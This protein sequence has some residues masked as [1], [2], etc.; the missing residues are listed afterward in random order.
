MLQKKR[1]YIKSKSLK[2]FHID[3][4]QQKLTFVNSQ[5]R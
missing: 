1:D 2:Y 4:S 3:K 5:R